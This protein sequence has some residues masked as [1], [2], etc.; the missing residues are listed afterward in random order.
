MTPPGLISAFKKAMD[1]NDAY[2]IFNDEEMIFYTKSEGYA[3]ENTSMP[4]LTFKLAELAQDAVIQSRKKNNTIIV[5]VLNFNNFLQ[6][7]FKIEEFNI[8]SMT[9]VKEDRRYLKMKVQTGTQ[10]PTSTVFLAEINILF[11]TIEVNHPTNKMVEFLISSQYIGGFFELAFLKGANVVI[12]ITTLSD[13]KLPSFLID[14][15]IPDFGIKTTTL[16]EQAYLCQGPCIFSHF[17]RL[18]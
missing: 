3:I 10:N 12:R 8:A 5:R 9:L 13:N 14:W 4:L 7:M 18:G 15:K 1:T 17:W 16:V 6:K 2:I 11:D